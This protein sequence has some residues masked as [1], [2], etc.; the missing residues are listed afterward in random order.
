LSVAGNTL[1]EAAMRT[2]ASL[3]K[4][5]VV[6]MLLTFRSGGLPA[7]EL[8]SSDAMP[9]VQAVI[10]VKGGIRLDRL[11][12]KYCK[13][14]RA[15][16]AF[17]SATDTI[18]EPLYPRL[19]GLWQWAQSSEQAIS[20]EF[21]DRAAYKKLVGS[22]IV[23][24]DA[25]NPPNKVARITLYLKTIRE[26]IA[27]DDFPRINGFIPFKD[28]GKHQRYAEV[29]GHELAHAYLIFTDPGYARIYEDLIRE[30]EAYEATR[31]KSG[32]A[33]RASDTIRWLN[34]LKVVR[35][36][37]ELPVE[38]IETEIWRELS[39]LPN[40]V[41]QPVSARPGSTAAFRGRKNP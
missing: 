32:K 22:I 16:G 23:E 28:L 29:L 37:F 11:K 1:P 41:A 10:P 17:L 30:T 25:L 18:G 7:Q 39:D 40:P 27:Q 35:D 20:I 34:R 36:Q 14:W 6:F 38:A 5:A 12:E 21:L 13:D 2:C 15:V 31:K 24:H 19:Y 3:W 8:F 9:D 4:A 26:A 33:F